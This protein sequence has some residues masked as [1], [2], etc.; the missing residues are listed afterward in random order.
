MCYCFGNFTLLRSRP[1][2]KPLSFLYF[3]RRTSWCSSDQ[4]HSIQDC[5]QIS[6]PCVILPTGRN[7]VPRWHPIHFRLT[8]QETLPQRSTLLEYHEEIHPQGYPVGDWILGWKTWL[9][10]GRW[11]KLT[12]LSR[13]QS[14]Y[15]QHTLIKK[16]YRRARSRPPWNTLQICCQ[17]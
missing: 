6:F 14:T 7:R 2:M 1:A 9:A 16:V 15:T 8:H 13:C 3:G 4:A 12:P 11:G 5:L 17:I 10:R